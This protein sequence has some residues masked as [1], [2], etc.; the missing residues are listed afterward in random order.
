MSSPS[1]GAGEA[2]A[3]AAVTSEQQQPASSSAEACAVSV[4]SGSQEPVLEEKPLEQ[5]PDGSLV[6]LEPGSW[7]VCFVPGIRREW[8]QAFFHKV[9]KHVFAMRP[10]SD[11]RW[12]LFEP[13]WTRLLT[14][15]ITA[16]Q[17]KK[18]LRWGAMGD[19]LLVRESIPG[20]SSQL[21][22]W[23]TCAVLAS[24]MLGRKY[25]AWTPHQLYRRLVREPNVCRIDVSALLHQDLEAIAEPG[26]RVV[27]ACPDCA[28]GAPGQPGAPKPFCMTCGR[29]IRHEESDRPRDQAPRSA[30]RLGPD[31]EAREGGM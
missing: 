3:D 20:H 18:F 11:G 8:W 27:E 25:W 10:E 17:A 5:N 6:A 23:M 9:H 1:P 29:D 4:P 28:P 21:R 13:W 24:H 15:T 14:A 12:T 22:G 2:S 16:Q 7:F 31:S 26:T 19:V 30:R